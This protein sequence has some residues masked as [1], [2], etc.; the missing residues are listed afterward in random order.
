MQLFDDVNSDLHCFI[1]TFVGGTS[2]DVRRH[3]SRM[4]SD[5]V[6]FNWPIGD[7]R[8][9][10]APA[11]TRYCGTCQIF[12]GSYS[13][14]LHN[15]NARHKYLCRAVE[16][17]TEVEP[18]AATIFGNPVDPAQVDANVVNANENTDVNPFLD[19][20]DDFDYH[21]DDSNASTTALLAILESGLNYFFYQVHQ[22]F[23]FLIFIVLQRG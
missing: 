21:G 12:T 1:C 23:V 8:H 22:K 5:V 13:T 20:A 7:K 19:G 10:H 2:R 4:H 15:S 17:A 16:P 18:I 9:R 14:E 11:G 3:A 6:D